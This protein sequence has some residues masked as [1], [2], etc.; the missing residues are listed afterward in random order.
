MEVRTN[1]S[2]KVLTIKTPAGE[3]EKTFEFKIKEVLACKN[4]AYVL[5][6]TAGYDIDLKIK[7]RNLFCLDEQGRIIWQV[8]NLEDEIDPYV[9]LYRKES[10]GLGITSW[11]GYAYDLNEATGEVSNAKLVK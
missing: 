1:K 8:Q 9:R 6:D 2:R 5:L 4:K 11:A 10:G 3:Y 7:N